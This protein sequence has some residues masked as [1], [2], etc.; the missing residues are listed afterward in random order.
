MPSLPCSLLL[1]AGLAAAAADPWSGLVAW[2][3]DNC[4]PLGG[5][6]PRNLTRVDGGLTA[7]R[8]FDAGEAVMSIPLNCTLSDADAERWLVDRGLEKA[9]AA[10]EHQWLV[11]LAVVVTQ[12]EPNHFFQPYYQALPSD[13]S[14]F[15]FN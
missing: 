11:A 13:A 12:R 14:N 10:L 6:I 9:A 8:A 15:L 2:F 7:P 5:A 1:V 4:A 3:E